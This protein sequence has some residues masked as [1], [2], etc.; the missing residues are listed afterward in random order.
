MEKNETPDI[1]CKTKELRF[2]HLFGY[3]GNRVQLLQIRILLNNYDS[4]HETPKP[5]NHNQVY[6]AV[7]DH[8][9]FHN[10]TNP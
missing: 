5:V 9:I 10:L 3:T 4:L 6:T 8:H 2:T 1:K 7:R